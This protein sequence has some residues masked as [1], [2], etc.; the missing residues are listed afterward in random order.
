[1]VR[2]RNTR[3]TGALNLNAKSSGT[4]NPAMDFTAH[5]PQLDVENQSLRNVTLQANIANHVANVLLD[6][7]SQA[8]SAFV[9][10]RGTVQLT[11]DYFA[12]ATLDA[13]CTS[14]ETPSCDLLPR[15][16]DR[17]PDGTACVVERTVEESISARRTHF[18][19]DVSP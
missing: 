18:A 6:L 5:A 9:R 17:R 8:L 16:A 7:D 14:T 4:L 3:I 15:P 2:S 12:D 11:G 13:P 19:G 10:G 1:M